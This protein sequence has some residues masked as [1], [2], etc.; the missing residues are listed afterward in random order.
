M[1]TRIAFLFLVILFLLKARD[2]QGQ[3]FFSDSDFEHQVLYYQPE[4]RVSDKDFAY[5]KMILR[6]TKSATENNPSNFNVADYFNILSA[7]LTLQE[8]QENLNL[9]FQKF[10]NADGSCE[11]LKSF[12]KKVAETSKYDPI[13]NA[14]RK[15]LAKCQVHPDIHKT[16]DPEE[17]ALEHGLD[18]SLVKAIYMIKLRDQEY[19]DGSGEWDPRQMPLDKDNQELINRLYADTKTYIGRTMVGEELET[20]MWSVIQHS[21]PEMM[22]KY[23]PVVH[24][25]VEKNELDVAPLKMLL[26]RYYSIT[27]GYQFFGSQ[28]GVMLADEYVRAELKKRYNID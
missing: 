1:R 26:D 13:R 7:F 27:E 15:E 16:F 12:E 18:V 10:A 22:K 19:R 28:E 25:A 24:E 14:Y 11:Y 9:A 6:E 20:V 3:K 21:N 23:L 8:S 4:Q 17:Y 2:S 5:A